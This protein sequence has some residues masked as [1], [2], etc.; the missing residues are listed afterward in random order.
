MHSY[1]KSAFFFQIHII[2]RIKCYLT[3]H[4]RKL[5]YNAYIIPHL[6][7]CCTV[8]DNINNN[9]TDRSVSKKAAK[10]F[11]DKNID[12]PPTD[13]FGEL[14]RMIVPERLEYQKNVTCMMLK[15]MNNLTPSYLNNLCT[16]HQMIMTDY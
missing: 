1:F 13:W 12:I 16:T 3:I 4:V 10:F 7:Y 11:L 14:K 9:L 6:D 15:I 5:F 8:C 2:C